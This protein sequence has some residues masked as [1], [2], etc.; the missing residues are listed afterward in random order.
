MG[1]FGNSPTTVTALGH[2]ILYTRQ[3]TG[4]GGNVGVNVWGMRI[5]EGS[6]TSGSTA[7]LMYPTTDGVTSYGGLS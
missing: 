7:R 1:L 5:E 6:W 2:E 4:P 3:F